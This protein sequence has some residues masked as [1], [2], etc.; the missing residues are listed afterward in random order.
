MVRKPT[1]VAMPALIAI[2][3]SVLAA[4]SANAADVTGK[5]YGKTDAQP[6]IT[7]SKAGSAYSAS[8]DYP[9]ST[10]SIKRGIYV[11]HQS[12]HKSVVSLAVVGGNVQFSIRSTISS[13]GDTDYARDEYDLNLS[14]DGSQLTGTVRR[15]ANIGSG[16][17][18][19][20]VPM[21]VTPITLFPTDWASRNTKSQP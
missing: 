9:D 15:V 19:D 1:Q 3:L 6:V 4:T 16:L 8:L 12:I 20:T 21:T 18:D 5:W 11:T 17:T 10:R 2:T 7:I 14:Q 13:R